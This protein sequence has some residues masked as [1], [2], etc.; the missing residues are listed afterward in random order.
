MFSYVNKINNYVSL[1]EQLYDEKTVKLI[2]SLYTNDVEART[3]LFK[4]FG[5]KLIEKSETFVNSKPLDL[6]TLICM[7]ATFPDNE[8]ECQEVAIIIYK[9]MKDDEPLP[10]ISSD[11]GILLAEKTLVSLSFYPRAMEKR[12][13]YHGAPSPDFYRRASKLL[14]EKNNMECIANHHE[15]WEAFF[16]EYFV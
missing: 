10:Y 3:S 1:I 13:K 14:F 2:R 5:H 12:W 15:K 9:R 16:S 4:A 6:L 7:T 8:Q 11:Q